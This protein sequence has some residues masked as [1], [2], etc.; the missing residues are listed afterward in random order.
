MKVSLIQ[1]LHII[2][3]KLENDSEDARRDH[4]F[5]RNIQQRLEGQTK[6]PKKYNATLSEM[7]SR[8]DGEA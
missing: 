5:D 7:V 8:A 6:Y 2:V 1:V 4:L 3:L